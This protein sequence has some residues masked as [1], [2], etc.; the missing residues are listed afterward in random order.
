MQRCFSWV[1]G[2]SDKLEEM[3]N[4]GNI[5]PSILEMWAAEAARCFV[6]PCLFNLWNWENASEGG[7]VVL[8]SAAVCMCWCNA[9][10]GMGLLLVAQ[11][12][13]ASQIDSLWYRFLNIFSHLI[14]PDKLGGSTACIYPCLCFS[15]YFF[16]L[17]SPSKRKSGSGA[18]DLI[19]RVYL[20]VL[21][22]YT[23]ASLLLDLAECLA[24]YY[25]TLFQLL[26]IK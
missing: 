23:N 3:C 7:S 4:Y 6:S 26:R 2:K 1:G 18:A 19:V 12:W 11:T 14:L 10:A 15:I 13:I 25:T 8:C 21:W 5:V 24:R 20:T 16:S 17:L 22:Y 9:S